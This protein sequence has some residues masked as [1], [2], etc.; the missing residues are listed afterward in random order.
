MK[1]VLLLAA[2]FVAALPSLAQQAPVNLSNAPQR[3]ARGFALTDE[4]APRN[5]GTGLRVGTN[6]ANVRALANGQSVAAAFEIG[7]FHQRALTRGLSWQTEALLYRQTTSAERTSGLRLP[8]LLV[9]NPLYNISLHVGPQLQWRTASSPVA[10]PEGSASVGTTPGAALTMGLVGGGE[11]RIGFL[12]VGLRYTAP[13]RELT[14]LPQLGDHAAS[15][16]RA[17]QVQVYLGAGF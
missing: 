2:A 13:L 16:W 1:K 6:W 10:T 9:F 8:V 5:H 4:D 12:R 3:P 14:D 17:G 11:A 15:A 7:V